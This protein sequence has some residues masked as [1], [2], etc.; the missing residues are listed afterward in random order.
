MNIYLITEKTEGGKDQGYCIKAETLRGA[1]EVVENEM[2]SLDSDSFE[3]IQ[4]AMALIDHWRENVLRSCI[5][6]GELRYDD[7]YSKVGDGLS[8]KF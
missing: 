7:L 4:Q 8:V 3:H 5:F 6:V 2:V 1:L